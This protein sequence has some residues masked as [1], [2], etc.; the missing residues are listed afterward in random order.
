MQKDILKDIENDLAF[1]SGPSYE[2]NNENNNSNIMDADKDSLGK[3]TSYYVE[4]NEKI[5]NLLISNC[6]PILT[7]IVG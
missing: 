3:R 6:E 2:N 4:E 5:L 1:S 7:E